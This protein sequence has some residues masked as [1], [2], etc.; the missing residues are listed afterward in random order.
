MG[1]VPCSAL[2]GENTEQ[3][4]VVGGGGNSCGGIIVILVQQF[5]FLIFCFLNIF[6]S[7]LKQ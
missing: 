6:R 3:V 5:F 2:T 1:F 7:S 4:V